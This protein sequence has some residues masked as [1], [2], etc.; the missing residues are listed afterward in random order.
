MILLKWPALQCFQALSI[1]YLWV[2]THMHPYISHTDTVVFKISLSF[3]LNLINAL[4]N[5]HK[6]TYNVNV[7]YVTRMLVSPVPFW[8]CS[9]YIQLL[10]YPHRHAHTTTTYTVQQIHN[11]QAKLTQNTIHIAHT[12][13]NTPTCTTFMLSIN[14]CKMHT[15]IILCSLHIKHT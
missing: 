14:T 11:I 10:W 8:L 15:Q 4:C 6:C 9:H 3:T 1:S 5:L 7:W 13:C 12:T 2:H